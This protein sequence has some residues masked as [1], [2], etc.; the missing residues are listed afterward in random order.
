MAYNKKKKMTNSK[1]V[2]EREMDG[3]DHAALRFF[4]NQEQEE[5]YTDRP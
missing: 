1:G 3:T 2:G 4:E 5:Q